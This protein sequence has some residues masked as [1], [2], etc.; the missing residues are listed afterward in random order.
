MSPELI[1]I[2]VIIG[3]VILFVTDKVS[4]DIVGL[5]IISALVLTGVVTPE[6]GVRGFSNKAT[7][8]VAFMFILSAA[9]LKTGALQMLAHKLA[10]VFR[11]NFSKGML[12]MMILIAVMS[13][14]VNNTPVVAVFI[15]V[16]IQI[17]HASGRSPSKMLIPLSFASIFGGTCTLIGT[18]TNILVSG[19]A[20]KAGLPSIDMFQPLRYGIFVLVIGILYMLFFGIKLLPKRS[21]NEDLGNKFGI[22]DYLSEIELLE[23]AEDAG[24]S[25][26]NSD[27][28]RD[29]SMDVLEVRRNGTRYTFP[30]GDFVLRVGDIL[31]VNCSMDKMKRLKS[32]AR[33]NV[34][35]AMRIGGEDV[36]GKNSTLV[37]MVVTADS[38]FAGKNLRMV[39]FRRR[40]RAV[41]LAVRSREDVKH[42]DLYD[43]KLQAGD[44]ILIEVKK[45]FI[46]EMKKQETRPDAPFVLLSEDPMVDFKKKKFAVVI[47]VIAAVITLAT[48]GVVDIMIGTIAGV[49][50]LILVG[51][52]TMEEAYHSIS[53]RIVFLLAGALCLGT[54]MGNSGLDASIAARVADILGPY[55]PVAV[56]SGLYLITSLLTETMSNNA[57]AALMTPIAI[58]TAAGMG[59]SATPLIMAVMFAA[60]SSFMTPIGYQT[61]TMVFSAGQYRFLD[62]VKVG[63]LL[64]IGFWIIATI[65]L[66]L[67]F[68]F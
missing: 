40:Y 43:I 59:V 7:V 29:L 27:L 13:A 25:I 64:N 20:E 31:K 52:L 53:W 37:E 32:R 19:I 68:P 15:P 39:D 23:N 41:P 42:E 46:R 5:L 60:S 14:F 17:G 22:R 51:V 33:V 16:V 26:M 56:L 63:I 6:E 12:L 44:V 24:K 47:M 3:A 57:T 21:M 1:T 62:F 50:A 28:V 10:P 49:T 45:H 54:A 65:L 35:S 66:P 9:L 18:S 48:L 11:D 61:N 2:A 55:G 30:P 34:Q 36:K 58:A 67:L 8:T 38:E 4:V